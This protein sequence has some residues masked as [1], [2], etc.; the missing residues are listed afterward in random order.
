MSLD[1]ATNLMD[2][3]NLDYF[4]LVHLE[5]YSSG[6]TVRLTGSVCYESEECH[7]GLDDSFRKFLN[8]LNPSFSQ[9]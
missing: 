8:K 3:L 1:G 6:I 9:K 2:F 4:S 5:S 7:T